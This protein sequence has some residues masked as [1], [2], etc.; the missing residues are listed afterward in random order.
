MIIFISLFHTLTIWLYT[1]GWSL[2]VTC[3]FIACARMDL[4]LVK[5]SWLKEKEIKEQPCKSQK[6]STLVNF[7]VHLELTS[8]CLEHLFYG[9]GKNLLEMK[10]K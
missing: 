6:T 8:V 1:K 5:A 4:N 9:N 10:K 2:Y 7:H 3:S